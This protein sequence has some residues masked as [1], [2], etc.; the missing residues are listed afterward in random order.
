MTVGSSLTQ[1]VPER[2]VKNANRARRWI[3]VVYK[4]VFLSIRVLI[5]LLILVSIEQLVF[6]LT[7]D[8]SVT[9]IICITNISY[10]LYQLVSMEV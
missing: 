6:L 8:K 10:L 5:Y 3:S 9:L 1:I 2:Q 4:Y 7:I